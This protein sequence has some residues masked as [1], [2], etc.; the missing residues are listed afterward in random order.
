MGFIMKIKVK[1]W[2]MLT[3]QDK[4]SILRAISHRQR[5]KKGA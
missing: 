5:I 4:L 3:M 2:R 1:S